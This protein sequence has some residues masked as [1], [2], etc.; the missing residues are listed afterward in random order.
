MLVK[1]SKPVTSIGTYNT[2]RRL[3][4]LLN[5]NFLIILG[6]DWVQQEIFIYPPTL[7]NSLSMK[8]I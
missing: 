1:G 5:K 6:P 4:H 3:F 7:G 2:R 8:V